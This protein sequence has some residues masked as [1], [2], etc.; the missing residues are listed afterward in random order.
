[1][2]SN[3]EYVDDSPGFTLARRYA[4]YD[5]PIMSLQNRYFSKISILFRQLYRIEVL[6]YTREYK[7]GKSVVAAKNLI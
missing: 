3:I 1:M 5:T 6:Y 2:D 7:K 4:K